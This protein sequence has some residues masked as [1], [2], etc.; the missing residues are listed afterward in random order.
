MKHLTKRQLPPDE[1]KWYVD[2]AA[3]AIAD[4]MHGTD[5]FTPESLVMMLNEALPQAK[6][7]I[8]KGRSK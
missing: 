3:K 4:A 5:P 6:A 7:I 2:G 8:R 1:W